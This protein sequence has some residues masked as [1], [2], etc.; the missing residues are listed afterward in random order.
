M[1]L[2]PCIRYRA[3]LACSGRIPTADAPPATPFEA[4]YYRE[5]SRL[6]AQW[7]HQMWCNYNRKPMPEPAFSGFS[8]QQFDQWL[9]RIYLPTEQ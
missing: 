1:T 7:V 2:T 9:Q 8:D 3:W 6:Y 4:A 5:S